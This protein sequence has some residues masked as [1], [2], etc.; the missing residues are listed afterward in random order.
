MSYEY[1]ESLVQ[2]GIGVRKSLSEKKI[3][4]IYGFSIIISFLFTPLL[5][6]W[7]VYLEKSFSTFSYKYLAFVW[8]ALRVGISMGGQLL[9]ILSKRLT[10]QT[11]II[12]FLVCNVIVI[13]AMNIC[14][15]YFVAVIF[16]CMQEICW[17]IISTVQKG[18]L[19]DYLDDRTRATMISFSSLFYSLGK[20]I[21]S[22]LF[23][24][25]A[26]KASMSMAL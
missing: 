22:M 3:A 6:L 16:F 20:I 21:A 26:E 14:N 1:R 17:I 13:I 25:V 4:Y 7:S 2:I 18:L 9:E 23:A 19:N 15:N 12:L 5:S 8:I 10:R 24:L 11:I